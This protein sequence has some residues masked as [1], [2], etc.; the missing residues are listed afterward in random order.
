MHESRGGNGGSG[1]PAPLPLENHKAIGLQSKASP[2][3]Q[4]NHK[5]SKPEF[6][7]GPLSA[8]QRNAI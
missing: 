8:C 1:K 6:N 5:A 4:E 2:E 7:I 3:P